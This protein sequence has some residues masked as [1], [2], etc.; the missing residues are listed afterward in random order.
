VAGKRG[1]DHTGELGSLLEVKWGGGAHHRGG[2]TVALLGWSCPPV[3]GQRGGRGRSR[4]GCRGAPERGGARGGSGRAE[5][6]LEEAG[7]GGVFVVD[8]A[9]NVGSLRAVPHGSATRLEDGHT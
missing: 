8:G 9:G 5:Q 3:R 6:W 4:K 1:R 2:L 7:A